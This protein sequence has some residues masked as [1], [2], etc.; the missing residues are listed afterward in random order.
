MS[1]AFTPPY[2]CCYTCKLASARLDADK[3]RCMLQKNF[4]KPVEWGMV[5]DH[6]W[7]TPQLRKLDVPVCS[8]VLHDFE[9]NVHNTSMGK[10]SFNST[11][12]NARGNMS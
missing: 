12:H 8:L 11:L 7:S 2:I 9:L 3:R 1:V 6:P 5:K 10:T 4:G